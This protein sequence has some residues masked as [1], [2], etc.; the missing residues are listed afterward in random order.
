VE[1]ALTNDPDNQELLKLREDLSVTDK[2]LK[3]QSMYIFTI[4]NVVRK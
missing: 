2:S 1:A 3:L 4:L